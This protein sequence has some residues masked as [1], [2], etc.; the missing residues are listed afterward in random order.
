LAAGVLTGVTAVL[1]LAGRIN[2]LWLLFGGGV[3]GGAGLLN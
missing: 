1:A 2:P 3:I